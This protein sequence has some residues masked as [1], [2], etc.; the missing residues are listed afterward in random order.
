MKEIKLGE[1]VKDIVSGFEGIA[2]T[3]LE[4]LNG[5]IRYTVQAKKN[6]DNEVPNMDVDVEQLR[7]V[8]DGINKI[9]K[10]TK[11]GGSKGFGVNNSAYKN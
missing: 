1:K 11:T 2:I 5:C 9:K 4:Y 3:R 10:V 8:N 7:K 6:K